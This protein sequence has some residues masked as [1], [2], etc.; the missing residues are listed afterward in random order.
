[1]L[2]A[3]RPTTVKWCGQSIGKHKVRSTVATSA[4]HQ[5]TNDGNKR[6]RRYNIRYPNDVVVAALVSNETHWFMLPIDLI[7]PIVLHRKMLARL[8]NLTIHF[9][10][11][12]ADG[13]LSCEYY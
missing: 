2:M 4:Q 7:V 13:V 3:H 8:P 9:P 12:E 1:M 11:W 5:S 10:R 6:E